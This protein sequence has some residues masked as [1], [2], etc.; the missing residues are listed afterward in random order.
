MKIKE[1][2]LMAIFN[3]KAKQPLNEGRSN[4]QAQNYEIAGLESYNF[5]RGL[6]LIA[7]DTYNTDYIL[8]RMMDDAI[9]SAAVDMYID[10]A[11][12]VDPQKQEIFWVDVDSTDDR[13]EKDLAKGLTD[14]LNRF[15][16]S[17]LR[18]DKE[19]REI[20]RRTIIYGQCPVRLDFI[21][22]LEDDRLALLDK[23]KPTFESISKPIFDNILSANSTEDMTREFTELNEDTIK[24]LDF[25]NM[26][27]LNTKN[28]IVSYLTEALDK[29]KGKRAL[30]EQVL[31]ED[32]LNK[33][34]KED[35]RRLLRGR[36]YSECIS[37]GTNIWELTAKG[38]TV[39]YMDVRKPNYF[40]S[41]KNVV[42]FA[43]QTGKYHINFEVGPYNDSVTNKDF[44]VLRRGQS[45]LDNAIVAWQILSALEDIL[46]LTRMTRSTLYRIFSVEV[47][48]KGD[49]ETRRI[50]NE[51]KNRIKSDETINVKEKIYNSEMRQVPLG[52]SIFI[53]TRNGIG[54]IDI[55]VVGGD[56]NLKDAIDLDYFKD[57]LFA[58][59]RIP[60]AFLGFSEDSGGLINTSLTRMDIRYART[61]K[62]IQ[63]IASEGLK[64]LCLK[65]LEFTRPE[66][67][68]RELPDFKI[69]FTS[70]NTEEDSQRCETKQTQ[71]DTLSKTLEAF[72]ALGIS[73]ANTPSLRN[74]LIR[75]WL[76]SDYLDIIEDAE[77]HGK[78]ST[79]NGDSDDF[80]G[81]PSLG[82]PDL[83][84][85]DSGG[86]DLEN[87]ESDIE[88][89]EDNLDTEEIGAGDEDFEA[90]DTNEAPSGLTRELS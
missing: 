76:G 48:N 87:F 40:I 82:G 44:F 73:V 53:P 80:S 89:D 68:L 61:I 29:P 39:A 2:I 7:S 77:A 23:N 74:E 20:I 4:M 72:E 26:T 56:V 66:S 42:N 6:R 16:K 27:D 81:S 22:K 37:S 36:W 15:L 62:G 58:A 28:R 78:L 19:L 35:V 12:Q 13:F 47:G 3:R 57:K 21:D 63:N 60:K 1:E 32:I 8:D 38:K 83:G 90:S 10:D 88:D 51:L 65:Y 46:M 17:D 49:T 18:M 24:S 9:I 64:D 31:N 67:V 33:T 86:P 55:K 54:N 45:Y 5:I 85:L 43:N 14:E 11:L 41:P 71:I 70:I 34:S 50:L 69:V 75:E 79:T 25:D 84:G 52:D 30:K 59:L